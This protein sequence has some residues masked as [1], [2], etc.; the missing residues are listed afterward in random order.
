M[1]HV[2]IILG[3]PGTGKT[4]TLLRIVEDALS[5]GISPERIAYLAFTRQ[6]ANEA[7]ERAMIQF[8]FDEARFPFSV[9]S[10]LSH[11]KSSGSS[12]T[13]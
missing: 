5:R 11:S 9:H 2:Q 3:P 8:G 10:T 4:T 1:R 13:R 6:A 7:K 12:E